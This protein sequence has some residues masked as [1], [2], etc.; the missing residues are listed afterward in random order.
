M[1]FY[2]VQP[3]RNPLHWKWNWGTCNGWISYICRISVTT[4][5]LSL[6]IP[7]GVGAI[8]STNESLGENWHTTRWKVSVALLCKCWRWENKDLCCHMGNVT[9]E[10]LYYVVNSTASQ[11]NIGFRLIISRFVCGVESIYDAF[12][13]AASRGRRRNVK[14]CM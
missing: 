5:Q 1:R 7:P 11:W 6:A 14:S 2:T 3:K 10:G 4:G 12:S 9:R 13:H 8:S